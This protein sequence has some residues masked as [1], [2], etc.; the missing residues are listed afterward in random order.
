MGGEGRLKRE[1]SREKWDQVTWS[2]GNTGNS[3]EW[4]FSPYTGKERNCHSRRR[5]E[6]VVFINM[7]EIAA[8][9]A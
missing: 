9:I 7:G 4:F 8:C 3:L 5:R 6:K 2:T 1:L